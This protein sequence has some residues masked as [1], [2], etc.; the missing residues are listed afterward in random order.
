MSN[1]FKV[2]GK[3]IVFLVEWIATMFRT[4]VVWQK[5]LLKIQKA[6]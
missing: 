6:T 5:K 1:V 2:N 3:D 4:M